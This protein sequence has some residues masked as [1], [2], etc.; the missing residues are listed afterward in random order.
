MRPG[1]TIFHPARPRSLT[2]LLLV[3]LAGAAC[4]I[5]PAPAGARLA[6]AEAAYQ[7][8]RH[9]KDR[10]DLARA[11]G[12]AEADGEPLEEVAARYGRARVDLGT[13]LDAVRPEDLADADRRALETMRRAFERDLGPVEDAGGEA[14]ETAPPDCDY[15]P[16]EVAQGGDPFEALSE[17]MY[18]CF[19]RAAQ[20]IPFEGEVLDRLTV[21]GRLPLTAAPDAR[22]RL[23]LSLKPVWQAFAGRDPARN[24]YRHLVRLSAARMQTAGSSVEGKVA[25]L[26]I[27]PAEIEAWLV[28]VLEAWRDATPDR[29]ME[30]W[31]FA[32]EA[33]RASR[34]LGAAVPV[35]ALR[36]INDRYYRDLGADVEA[37]RIRYDIEPRAGKDPVAFTTFGA[38][39][40]RDGDG[41][42]PGEP[43][44]FASYRVGGLDNLNELL[45]ETGHAVHIAAIRT[46]PAFLDWP[47]SDTFT[48]AIADVAMLEMYERD[49][50]E[51]YLG[52]S[53][54]PADSI[55]SRYAGIVMDVAWSLME[56]R[57]HRDPGLDP[58]TVWTALTRDY[59]RI[60]PHT[61]LSWWG[62]R[63]QLIS[64]P[65]YMLNYAAGAILIA[66]LRARIKE[67]HGPFT[68]GDPAWYPWISDRLYRFGLE[69]PTKDVIRD[70]LGRPPSPR[71]ILDDLS[72]LRLPPGRPAGGRRPS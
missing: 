28:S 70:F 63:G 12:A 69:R 45:H 59:L 36:G 1:S 57:L 29:T 3:V 23:F 14:A 17:R 34:A 72:R 44:V 11:R 22:R 21:F 30:P 18:D 31:D 24:P 41:W 40:R 67:L 15:D 56:I 42:S 61:E 16:V 5:R 51:K 58:D 66:D 35:E 47:D 8:T 71:A 4:S 65:G 55:R 62:V 48:E 19:A 43:W 10:I 39:P 38:R 13:T 37:L 6:A 20:E 54:A 49:W 60:R 2:A 7:A 27:D 25:D 50:Q 9:L 32:W 52:K 53:A 64:L 46:R 33:G 26:G 68:T